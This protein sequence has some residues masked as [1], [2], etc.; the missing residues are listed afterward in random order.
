AAQ[1]S[2]AD[3]T[4]Q[5]PDPPNAFTTDAS[6][7]DAFRHSG[8]TT[9]PT[10]DN[11]DSISWP[12]FST[13]SSRAEIVPQIAAVTFDATPRSRHNEFLHVALHDQQGPSKRFYRR[14]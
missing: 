12:L 2:T 13:G 7:C 3:S 9:C 4:R 5:P 6:A 14:P 8:L 1:E 11:L 10:R